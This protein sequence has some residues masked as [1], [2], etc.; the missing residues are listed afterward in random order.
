MRIQLFVELRG[1]VFSSTPVCD[2]LL[3]VIDSWSLFDVGRE[4]LGALEPRKKFATALGVTAGSVS[5]R[6]GGAYFVGP[7]DMPDG[8]ARRADY[9]TKNRLGNFDRHYWGTTMTINV[10][11]VFSRPATKA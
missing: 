2:E 8:L 9:I 11:V 1:G 4:A 7:K 6:K 10:G 5:S 3:A